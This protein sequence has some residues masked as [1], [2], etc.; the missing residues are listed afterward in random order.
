M[1]ISVVIPAHNE[2]GN[3]K[4]MARLLFG[5]LG[6]NLMQVVV[7]DDCSTDSTGKILDKLKKKYPKL[8]VVHRKRN[9]GVGNAI[10]E[11]LKAISDQATHVLLLDCDFTKNTI[12]IKKLVK[13]GEKADGV[14]G[15]RF[16][17][18]GRLEGYAWPKKIANRSFHILAK[19]ILGMRQ[20][21]VTNNFK[22]YRK[23]IIDDL[24]PYLESPGFSIN[25]EIGIYAILLGYNIKEVPVS[26]IERTKGMGISNFKVLK[27]GPG[28]FK[29]F[30]KSLRYKYFGFPLKV[31][32]TSKNY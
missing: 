27:V 21:D 12:D 1:K 31:G 14:V 28:Y 17:K 22:F 3:I 4:N 5:N 32:V 6:K 8:T 29:V 15:A 9:G 7:V 2:E 18:G 23:Q 30:M 16:I 10:R 19:A 20:W 11:G 26:W 13:A 24:K 25:A